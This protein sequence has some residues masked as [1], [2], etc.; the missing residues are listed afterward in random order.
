MVISASTYDETIVEATA[1]GAEF[2]GKPLDYLR[3]SAWVGDAY[4]A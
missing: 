4:Y 2:M 1:A 3:L